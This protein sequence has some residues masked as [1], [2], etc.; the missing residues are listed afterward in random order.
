MENNPLSLSNK[1]PTNWKNL[2]FCLVINIKQLL[3]Q[4][5]TKIQLPQKHYW[6]NSKISVSES[7]CIAGRH[8][9]L[10]QTTKQP[11]TNSEPRKLLKYKQL[12]GLTLFACKKIMQYK[13]N[14]IWTSYYSSL[15]FFYFVVKGISKLYWNNYWISFFIYWENPKNLKQKI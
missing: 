12:S 15:T 13:S 11:L 9:L 5:Y 4:Q 7:Y 1:K 14:L 8:R 6:E 10:G 2:S 3:N